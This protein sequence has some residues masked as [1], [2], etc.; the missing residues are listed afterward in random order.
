MTETAPGHTDVCSPQ[1]MSGKT[2]SAGTA[3]F[4]HRRPDRRPGRPDGHGRRGRSVR[5]SCRARMSSR[6]TG[7]GR[8]TPWPPLPTVGSTPGTCGYCR[9]GRL[10]LHLDRLKD[11]IISGGENIYPAEIEQ[12]S[13]S[14][15][16]VGCGCA[17]VGVPD[18]KWGEVGRCRHRAPGRHHRSTE[19]HPAI[20]RRQARQYKIPKKSSSDGGRVGARKA[21]GKGPAPQRRIK[22]DRC[23]TT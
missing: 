8:R 17:V 11:M 20:P 4:L 19:D 9:R 13:C 15:S 22:P 21:S 7:T 10:R 5:S 14:S 6:G 2:G 1:A 3:A 12:L 23:G 16:A 18:E